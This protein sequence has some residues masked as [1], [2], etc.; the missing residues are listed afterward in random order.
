M[1]YSNGLVSYSSKGQLELVLPT[2]YPVGYLLSAVTA[3]GIIYLTEFQGKASEYVWGLTKRKVPVEL[4]WAADLPFGTS[5]TFIYVEDGILI[6][7]N[8]RYPAKPDKK[9][10]KQLLH[11]LSSTKLYSTIAEGPTL[12]ENA[13][14]LP[15]QQYQLGLNYCYTKLKIRNAAVT[16]RYPDTR[17]WLAVTPGKFPY[18]PYKNVLMSGQFPVSKVCDKLTFSADIHTG[19]IPLLPAFPKLAG[20]NAGRL[21]VGL[22][23]PCWSLDDHLIIEGMPTKCMS[24]EQDIRTIEQK[25]EVIACEECHDNFPVAE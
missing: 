18:I 22:S 12:P 16:F 21:C 5:I 2:K 23:V 11:I 19:R 24:C 13:L 3:C 14:E 15:Y 6:Y 20:K 25:T 1:H 17:F 4:L 7:D 9:L 10:L 8:N